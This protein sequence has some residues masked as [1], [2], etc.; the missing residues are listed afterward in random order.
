MT[1]MQTR[2]IAAII[3]IAVCV[4]FSILMLLPYL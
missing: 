3:T 1:R 4:G 2:T